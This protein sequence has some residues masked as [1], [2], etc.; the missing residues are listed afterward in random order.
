MKFHVGDVVDNHWFWGD[1]I[2]AGLN[3]WAFALK[4]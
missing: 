4:E 1:I 3:R 2:L